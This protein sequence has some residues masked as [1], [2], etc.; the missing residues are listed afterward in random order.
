MA[1]SNEMFHYKNVLKKVQTFILR[2]YIYNK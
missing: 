2:N 1:F